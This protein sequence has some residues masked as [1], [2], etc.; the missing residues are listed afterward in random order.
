MR[1]LTRLV[2]LAMGAGLV[3]IA[4]SFTASGSGGP[5]AAPDFFDASDLPGA[6]SGSSSNTSSSGS[7]GNSGGV[8][9]GTSSSSGAS[10]NAGGTGSSNGG[11]PVTT[12]DAG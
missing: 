8:N 5:G 2:M 7:G 12:V 6:S 11:S 9:A 4:C 1:D 3:A 10:G